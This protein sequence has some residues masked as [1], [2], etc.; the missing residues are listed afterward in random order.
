MDVQSASRMGV[1]NVNGNVIKG[2]LRNRQSSPPSVGIFLSN[3]PSFRAILALLLPDRR[4]K[5][6]LLQASFYFLNFLL[7]FVSHFIQV[8]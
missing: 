1:I 4:L 7:L 5:N 8:L 3:L 6:K 2:I